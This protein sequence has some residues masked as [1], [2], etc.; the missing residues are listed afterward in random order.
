MLHSRQICVREVKMVKSNT[1]EETTNEISMAICGWRDL[2]SGLCCQLCR[3][4]QLLNP[5]FQCRKDPMH[6]KS[7]VKYKCLLPDLLS[8]NLILMMFLCQ[9]HYIFEDLAS[10]SRIKQCFGSNLLARHLLPNFCL[11]RLS[12]LSA[13]YCLQ[14]QNCMAGS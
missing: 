10:I 11:C 6:S 5:R 13:I 7:G 12:F 9:L 14:K 4:R 2:A 8:R 3:D 1:R